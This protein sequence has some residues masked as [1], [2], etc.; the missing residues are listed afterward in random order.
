LELKK[1]LREEV[2]KREKLEQEKKELEKKHRDTSKKYKQLKSDY[3]VLNLRQF[4][5]YNI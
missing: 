1:N 4:A 2:S 3:Q 5:I